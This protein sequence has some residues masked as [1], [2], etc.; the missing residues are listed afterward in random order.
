[1]LLFAT[2]P[3][4]GAASPAW[5]LGQTVSGQAALDPAADQDL[6]SMKIEDLTRVKVYSAS[7]HLEDVRKAPS[8]VSILSAEEIRK[9]GWRTLGE[10]LVS[11]RG[12]YTSYDRQYTYLGVRGFMRPGD[13][14][15]RILLL[16]NGHRLNDN[17]YDTAA[18]GTEFPLDLDLIDHIEVV[19]GPGSSL[20]GGNA[21]FG[22]IN[23]I[24]RKPG[25]R[26]MAETSGETGSYESRMGSA[27]LTGA[28]GRLS[29][30]LSGSM[31]RSAG[32][33][34]LF[35]P[36]FASPATNNGYADHVDGGHFEHAFAEVRYGDFHVNGMLGQRIQ[37]I[38]TGHAGA[39]FDDPSARDSDARGYVEASLDRKLR[40]NTELEVRAWYDAYAY[41]GG[42]NYDGGGMMPPV[43]AGV[44]ARA[45]WV[46]TE[47]T[48]TR[49]F[50]EQRITAGT[51]Y[52]YSLRIRQSAGM[53]GEPSEFWFERTPW[54]AAV[55][56][57][58]ELHLV[59]RA[60]VHAGARVDWFS[61]YDEALSPRAALI[62]LPDDRTAVKYIV[63]KA[64]RIPN[65]YEEYY[66]DGVTV[67]QG[68]EKLVPEQILSHEAVVERSLRPWLTVSADGFYNQLKE[69]IDQ[70]PA[71]NTT[72]SYF[73]N[74]DRVH[75]KGLEAEVNAEREPGLGLRASYTATMATDDV[76]HAPLANAPHSQAKLNGSLP[77]R[78]WGNGSVELLY[79]SALTDM[80]GRRVSPYLL[81]SLTVATKPLWGG[82]QFS[83]TCY[84]A[85][86][87][88]WSS[89]VGPNDPEDQIRMDGRAW[90]FKVTYRVPVRGGGREP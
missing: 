4:T 88:R 74:D 81:P 53:L 3:G 75:A 36:E 64:F 30:L 68:S 84:D 77:L 11:L 28:R 61:N 56:G 19:R 37:Q 86:N 46:G 58:A 7:R 65:A 9:Y 29:A 51:E 35:F 89:P 60:I 10:A 40:E 22:V 87:R 17:V 76:A 27:T 23:V 25:R 71:G 80:R 12:F 49:P 44:K 50:G 45:D 55:F 6:L 67:T 38:P 66:A 83:S 72:L 5:G 34:R 59:P 62:Y 69:L 48:V 42:G 33:P 82:W 41:F 54:Q 52:Q 70:V 21:I 47:A 90:R 13:D 85:T 14:N 43:A 32:A 20:F 31:D 63:G 57:D 78:G 8:S 18:I 16:V 1:M 24:T 39:V 73:V 26:A 2:V 15:P 79:A